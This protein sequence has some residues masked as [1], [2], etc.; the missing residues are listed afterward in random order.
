MKTEWEFP[1]FAY[2]F[3]FEK[4]HRFVATISEVGTGGNGPH[5]G[6]EADIRIVPDTETPHDHNVEQ[7]G[8]MYV[9]LPLR[10]E[11]AEPLAHQTAH[12]VGQQI[13]FRSGDFRISYGFITCKRLP[14]SEDEEREIDEKPY[15]VRLTLQEVIAAPLFEA[16]KLTDAGHSALPLPLLEQFNETRRDT[17][18]V[19]Q[20][21]GYFRILESL[22]DTGQRQSLKRSLLHYASLRQA[23]SELLPSADYQDFVNRLVETRHRCAHLKAATRYGYSPHHPQVKVEVIPDLSLLEELAYRCIEL[24]S[25]P[26]NEP[27]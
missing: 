19:S 8:S 2:D 27:D 9:T 22:S 16:R 15:S 23:F 12:H 7:A 13:A 1:W 14:E 11:E 5:H 18:P 4:E 3:R 24:T 6:L 20:F 25:R 26:P 21:L 17:N 10:P